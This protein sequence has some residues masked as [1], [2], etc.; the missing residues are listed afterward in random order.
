MKKLQLLKEYLTYKVKDFQPE[1]VMKSVGNCHVKGLFSLVLNVDANGLLTRI[2]YIPKGQSHK[3]TATKING[4]GVSYPDV[5]IHSHSQDIRLTGLSGTI[6][7]W[8]FNEPT[9]DIKNGYS[10][11]NRQVVKVLE[12]EYKY[13]KLGDGKFTKTRNSYYLPYFTQYIRKGDTVELAARELHSISVGN[14]MREPVAWL[15]EE[16][17]TSYHENKLTYSIQT[18]LEKYDPKEHYYSLALDVYKRRLQEIIDL[19]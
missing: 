12:Y 6:K 5:A 16:L 19:L 17:S 11:N 15:V 3:V 9:V 10:N 7:H 4:Q 13:T 1:A 2:Y 14:H 8:L 18:D